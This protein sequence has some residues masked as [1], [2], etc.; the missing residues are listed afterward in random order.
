MDV[1]NSLKNE[2]NETLLV[3]EDDGIQYSDFENVEYEEVGEDLCSKTG[4]E[5]SLSFNSV[6]I[7][8]R[9]A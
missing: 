4:D 5:F 7:Q 6:S 8:L 2:S 3:S 1:E 9:Q